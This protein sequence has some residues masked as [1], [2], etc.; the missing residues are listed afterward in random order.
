M[1][2][3]SSTKQFK[4]P[5]IVLRSAERCSGIRFTR[6]SGQLLNL[7][8]SP[9]ILSK[10]PPPHLLLS[11]L[12]G[13]NT[14]LSELPNNFP[15]NWHHPSLIPHHATL[16]HCLPS[17]RHL[18]P[19]CTRAQCPNQVANPLSGFKLPLPMTTPSVSMGW[20]QFRHVSSPRFRTLKLSDQLKLQS[21][22]YFL[23]FQIP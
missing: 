8:D 16:G 6:S 4:D 7:G 18:I 2:L 10:I 20:H 1:L 19:S 5:A 17:F 14:S 13:R 23:L 11:S 9:Y 21:G 3:G 15:A 22:L 12:L